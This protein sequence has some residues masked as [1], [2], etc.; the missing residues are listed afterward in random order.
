MKKILLLT[1][2]IASLTFMSCTDYKAKGKELSEQLIQM[3]EKQDTTAVLALNDSISAIE[4]E[5]KAT[6][7]TTALNQFRE[8]V[9][10][11]LVKCAPFVTASKV[12]SGVS[13]EEA[14]QEVIEDALNGVGD[15]TTITKSISAAIEQEKKQGKS[16]AEL[17]SRRSTKENR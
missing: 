14:V 13:K 5:I 6:G 8:A 10:E 3:C 11:A 7:D 9:S 4:E 2:A 1:A 17:P 15:I 16:P 12:E